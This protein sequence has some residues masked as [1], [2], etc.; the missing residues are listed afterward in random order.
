M[1]ARGLTDLWTMAC[2]V[3]KTN[4]PMQMQQYE[5]RAGM[6][7]M[8]AGWHGPRPVCGR[9]DSERAQ[10]TDLREDQQRG[11]GGA[12]E[13]GQ[14]RKVLQAQARGVEQHLHAASRQARAMGHM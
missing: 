7:H 5:R 4:L 14:P 9:A 6:L 11:A 1:H 2:D 13:A 8:Q 12:A 3:H 10:A